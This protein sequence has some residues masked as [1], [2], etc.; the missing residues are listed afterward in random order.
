LVNHRRFELKDT[1]GK[2]LYLPGEI[3]SKKAGNS[4]GA[5]SKARTLKGTHF[6]FDRCAIKT[7]PSSATGSGAVVMLPTSH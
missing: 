6:A 4:C 1:L 3:L 5:R 2:Y 7:A